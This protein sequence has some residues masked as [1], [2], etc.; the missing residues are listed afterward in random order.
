MAVKIRLTRMGRHKDPF[1]RIVVSDSRTARD[2]ICIEQIGHF[3]PS[4]KEGG[5]FLKEEL[6]LKWLQNGAIPTESVRHMLSD[7]GI[8]AKFHALKTAKK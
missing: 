2:G 4:K 5:V 7:A 6:A 8:L 3:D 1:Y